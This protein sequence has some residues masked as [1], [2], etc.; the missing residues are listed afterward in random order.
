MLRAAAEAEDPEQLR[1]LMHLASASERIVDSA[2][3]MT[4][5]IESDDPPHPVIAQALSEA[6]EIVCD[7]IVHEGSH[8][9][10]RTLGELGLHTET[11]MEIL[12]IDRDRRWVYRPRSSRTSR[13]A[14]GCWRSAPRRAPPGCASGA[15]TRVP[16]A[17]RRT[18]PE[19][20]ID[21]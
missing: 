10:G 1:G 7:A 19:L 12:A 6:D 16:R 11:G 8:V 13:S 14:T 15:V 20:D 21:L 2:Q 5:L 18:D 4:K 17:R 9:A 3:S